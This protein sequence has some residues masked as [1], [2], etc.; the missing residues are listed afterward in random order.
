MCAVFFV[1][2]MVKNQ[3]V[4]RY[5]L[6]GCESVLPMYG[7]LNRVRGDNF[8]AVDLEQLRCASKFMTPYP[9]LKIQFLLDPTRVHLE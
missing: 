3:D 2:L 7:E 1:I 5:S 4:A 6:F 8:I 9:K